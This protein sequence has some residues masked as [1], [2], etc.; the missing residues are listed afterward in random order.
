MTSATLARPMDAVDIPLN[1]QKF[2][3]NGTQ[4]T[5]S[6]K[7]VSE[8]TL[9]PLPKLYQLRKALRPDVD[10][11]ERL[12]SNR[13]RTYSFSAPGVTALELTYWLDFGRKSGWSEAR[14]KCFE[15]ASQWLAEVEA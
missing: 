5:F 1:T 13:T 2:S 3:T 4:V 11:T 14:L 8:L 10:Y 6:T 15:I 7:Q 12:N 9:I